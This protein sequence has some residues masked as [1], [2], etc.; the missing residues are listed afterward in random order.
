MTQPAITTASHLGI[1]GRIA[2]YFQGAQITPLLA[3]VAL[4]GMAALALAFAGWGVGAAAITVGTV[5]LLG[6]SS[7][8]RAT[9]EWAP[10][11]GPG[12][13]G[14]SLRGRF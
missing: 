1:S 5:M 10:V 14:A 3:L 4:V 9:A 13:S 7:R 6:S 2:A 8:E 11:I 12:F